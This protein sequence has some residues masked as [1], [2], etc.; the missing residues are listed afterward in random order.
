[1][2]QN[3]CVKNKN[4]F[5]KKNCPSKYNACITRVLISKREN[6]ILSNNAFRQTK[7]KMMINMKK[8]KLGHIAIPTFVKFCSSSHDF[9]L[10]WSCKYLSTDLTLTKLSLFFSKFMRSLPVKNEVSN[11][12]F[13]QIQDYKMQLNLLI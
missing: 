11:T 3:D 6:Q 9:G 12:S 2:C 5:R 7:E 10:C 4:I 1:M 13:L 8:A